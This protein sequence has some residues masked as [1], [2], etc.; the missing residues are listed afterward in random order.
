MSIFTRR[1]IQKRLDSFANVIGKGKLTQI[2]KRLNMEGNE[3]NTQRLLESLAATWEVVI[4]SALVESG[5]TEY[6]KTISNGKTP[7][8]FFS[9]KGVLLMGDIFM[10]SDD[11]Q[12]KKNPATEFS[13]VIGQLWRDFC[14]RSG[15]LS[16]GCIGDVVPFIPLTDDR[17]WTMILSCHESPDSI[18]KEP[19]IM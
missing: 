13:F 18:W 3:L 1:D 4:M 6:E 8:F 5:D 7:D 11:Q 17:E 9:C 14:F 12:H 15:G 16:W 19:S 10:T 2:V